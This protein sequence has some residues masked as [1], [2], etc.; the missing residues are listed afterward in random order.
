L[1][2][3]STGIARLLVRTLERK[4]L[5]VLLLLLPFCRSPTKLHGEWNNKVGFAG[6]FV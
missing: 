5:R 6:R 3:G 2:A 1:A 4:P